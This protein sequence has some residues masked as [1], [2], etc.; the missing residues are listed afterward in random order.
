MCVLTAH[1]QILA[2]A[3]YD[4]TVKLYKEDDDD[5]ICFATLGILLFNYIVYMYSVP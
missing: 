3:S 4:D 2:S 1:S 5:W